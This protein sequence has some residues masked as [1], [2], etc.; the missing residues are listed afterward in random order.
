MTYSAKNAKEKRIY[1]SA[2]LITLSY[3]QIEAQTLKIKLRTLKK[4]NLKRDTG[5]KKNKWMN[6]IINEYQL[7]CTIIFL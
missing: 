1:W 5:L 6:R 4:K 7:C 2:H 3:E